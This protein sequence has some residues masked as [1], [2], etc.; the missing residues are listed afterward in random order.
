MEKIKIIYQD[1]WLMLIDKPS[2]LIVNRSATAKKETLQDWLEKKIKIK[3]S[4]IEEGDDFFQRT[5]IVHRLDKETSGL[6]LVAKNRKI[7][8][9]LL[10]NFKKREVEKK[11]LALVHGQI[12]PKKGD[13]KLPLKRNKFWRTKM[14][15]DLFGRQ[16]MT[17]YQLLAYYQ[18]KEKEFFSFLELNLKTG[19]TH[20]IRVHLSYLGYPLVADR[21]YLNKKKLKKD[22]LWCPRLFLQAKKI[23]FIHPYYQKKMTFELKLAKDLQ[24]SLKKLDKL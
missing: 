9:K 19:R 14:S 22:I 10:E 16:A 3:K 11:Y 21:I 7:F 13:I 20:Q 6:L 15:V 2:G 1:K 18:N 4:T 12:K 5:G 17:E 8:Y 24:E 23:S